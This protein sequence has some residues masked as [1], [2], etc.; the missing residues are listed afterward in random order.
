MRIE[1]ARRQRRS[2]LAEQ[3]ARGFWRK[4]QANPEPIGRE[5]IREAVGPLDDDEAA[6]VE[7]VVEARV[8]QA[9]LGLHPVKVRVPQ[10]RLGRVV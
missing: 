8:F 9:S 5:Q 3:P 2:P 1:L 10:R 6:P 7:Q 4:L